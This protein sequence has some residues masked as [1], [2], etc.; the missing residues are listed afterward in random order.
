MATYYIVRKKE[1]SH[2][3]VGSPEAIPAIHDRTLKRRPVPDVLGDFP[4]QQPAVLHV[5]K[6]CAVFHHDLAAQHGHAGPDFRLVAFPGRIIGLVQPGGGDGAPLL[7]GLVPQVQ[8]VVV[9]RRQ[10]GARRGTRTSR[11]S[12]WTSAREP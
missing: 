4:F 9:Q 5:A 2:M 3:A 1:Q 7:G 6:K 11:S 10:R 12:R 8:R